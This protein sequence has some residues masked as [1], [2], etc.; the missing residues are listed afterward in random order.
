MST[1]IHKSAKLGNG[2]SV[3]EETVIEESVVI[4]DNCT[5]S[6]HV[7]IL[8]G[9]QIGDNVTISAG[10]VIGKYPLR[11]AISAM[12]QEKQLKPILIGDGVLIGA[13]AVLAAG[14]EIARGVLIG[15]LASV[16]EETRIGE[17]TIIGRGTTV[18]NLCIIGSFCK[19]QS[20]V[21]IAAYSTIEDYVFI[22]PCVVTSNDNFLGRT[23]ER[24]KHYKGM[25]MRT[26]SRIGINASILPGVEIGE[27]AVVGAGSVVTRDVPARKVAVG[28][29]ARV[30]RDVPDE[31]LLENQD[32]DFTTRKQ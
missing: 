17:C 3:G 14:S 1:L 19:V 28:I 2:T 29:P 22:G 8:R 25:T 7:V 10:S 26:G 20:N 21:Y 16:R 27:D 30:L 12:T 15:D 23:K 32:A 11:S 13:N 31:Q 4:G 18:D 24:F 5:I 9:A 6:H